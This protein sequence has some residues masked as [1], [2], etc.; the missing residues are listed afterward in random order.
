MPNIM[1][2]G[3]TITAESCAPADG[4]ISP[5]ETVTI[6]FGMKNVGTAPTSNLV[7]TLQ[8]T[9]GITSPSGPQS[10]GAVP[11]DGSTVSRSFTFTADG[12]LACGD[13]ITTTFDL[14]DG[15]TNLGT[16]TYIV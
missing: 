16:V 3:S 15:A 7:A 2:A 4:G 10:Y 5:G 9:G 8:A 13:T 6:D 11:N 12:L 14:Q 1:S